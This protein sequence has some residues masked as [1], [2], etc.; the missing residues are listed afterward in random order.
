MSLSASSVSVS[1]VL[2]WS[3]G[4]HEATHPGVG[5]E[6]GSTVAMQGTRLGAYVAPVVLSDTH[7]L[8]PAERVLFQQHLEHTAGNGN[9]S[10]VQALRIEA[11][12]AFKLH[13][14]VRPA[15]ENRSQAAASLP[16]E[17]T[18]HGKQQGCEHCLSQLSEVVLTQQSICSAPYDTSRSCTRGCCSKVAKQICQ[19]NS[20]FE[21]S[22]G[23]HTWN[24][25]SRPKCFFMSVAR[26]SSMVVA[27]RMFLS[28]IAS[29]SE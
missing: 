17:S 2:H 14:L 8:L 21:R 19:P 24:W 18:V 5:E 27:R 26:T 4:Q 28:S 20:G 25:E 6:G 9:F 29:F 12:L 16:Q 22:A 23:R 10:F 15:L 7:P 1:T 3:A 13:R 11:G